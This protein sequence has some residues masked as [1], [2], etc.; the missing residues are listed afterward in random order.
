MAASL[1]YPIKQRGD[2]SNTYAAP[3]VRK[4]LPIQRPIASS[5]P[6][7]PEP[8]LPMEE[9]AHIL[10]TL[11]NMTLVMERNPKAFAGMKEEALRT[12][13]LV[14][15]NAQYEG[16]AT[17]ET[18]NYEGK[19]DI[20]VRIEGSNIFIAEC[21]FWEG[22]DSLSKKIDQ[23]LGYASWRDSKTAIIIFN[24]NK[25]MS[26]VLMQI[27]DTVKGHA[28]CK[29]QVSNYKNETGFRF[30]FGQKNDRNR[31]LNLTVLVFDV[32]TSP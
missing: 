29:S 12:H 23:L 7:K 1:G 11:S 20:L 22:P 32:P 21:M 24:R 9:Y 28:N 15:L 30:L 16:Q 5:S 26:A 10:K 17:G 3:V 19:T 31:E 6:F 8:T 27:P 13:F 2:V 4:K 14:Q 18:F 25:N